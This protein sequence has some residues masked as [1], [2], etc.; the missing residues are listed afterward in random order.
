MMVPGANNLRGRTRKLAAF[1]GTAALLALSLG[2]A[3]GHPADA[4]SESS[5][6]R[7]CVVCSTGGTSPVV[8]PNTPPALARL[9]P[10]AAQLHARTNDCARAAAATAPCERSPP[11][12]A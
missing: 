11:L 9:A 2:A 5:L 4:G 6:D 7:P 3:H 12:S 1:L 8:V 10:V